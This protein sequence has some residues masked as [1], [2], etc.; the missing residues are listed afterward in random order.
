[1]S[2]TFG[3]CGFRTLNLRC[4]SEKRRRL[5]ERRWNTW[6]NDNKPANYSYLTNF[7]NTFDFFCV[8]K[9]YRT[10]RRN[11]KEVRSY[12]RNWSKF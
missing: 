10:V 4:T 5:D 9:V 2:E 8:I 3:I 6:N 1:M 12:E 11:K 7:E